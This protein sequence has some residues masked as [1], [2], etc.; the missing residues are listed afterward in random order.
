MNGV[1]KGVLLSSALLILSNQVSAKEEVKFKSYDA[2][3]S[4]ASDHHLMNRFPGAVMFDYQFKKKS[5]Y[6]LIMGTINFEESDEP[7]ETG[8]RVQRIE[9]L[10]GD[11][12]R[13]VYDYPKSTSP[14]E[15]LERASNDL[16]EQG[17]EELFNCA[18]EECGS[19]LGWKS[20][21]YNHLGEIDL[22]QQYLVA[23][24]GNTTVAFYV[25]ELAGQPRG[26]FDVVVG[27]DNHA[28]VNIYFE[29][30]QYNVALN[31]LGSARAMVEKAISEQQ[32][33]IV[34]GFADESGSDEYN[35]ALSTKRAEQVKKRL[36]ELFAIP[37]SKVETIGFGAINASQGSSSAKIRVQDRRVDILLKE[38]S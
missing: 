28:K 38:S 27:I 17:F 2:K 25:N 35:Q 6:E 5:D 18:K 21:L 10:S 9:T 30:D 15:I 19:A 37:E 12:T 36:V 4:G 1:V 8:Y 24:H 14:D 26:V 3:I 29:S 20:Y 7:E 16:K 32:V 13:I 11:I 33:L 23:N 22:K 34:Q 31:Q